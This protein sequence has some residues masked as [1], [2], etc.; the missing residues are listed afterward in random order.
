MLWG[1]NVLV[2]YI[3]EAYIDNG[4]YIYKLYVYLLLRNTLLGLFPVFIPCV[5][6]FR[7]KPFADDQLTYFKEPIKNMQISRYLK[8][9]AK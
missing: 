6:F 4:R 9:H 1:Y 7:L 2:W 3:D 5:L 8:V